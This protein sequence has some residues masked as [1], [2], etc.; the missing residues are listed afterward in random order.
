MRRRVLPRRRIIEVFQEF[1]NVI[2][3]VWVVP[4]GCTE[5]EIAMVAGGKDGGS[6]GLFKAGNGG[7]GGQV[8]YVS[9]M[10]VVPGERY[11]MIVGDK[12]Q[13]SQ[14][15]SYIALSGAGGKGGTNYQDDG[16]EP[17][18]GGDGRDGNYLFNGK[19]MD[20]YPSKYGAGGGAGAYIRGWDYG[21]ISGGNG[22][23][24][25]GGDGAGDYDNRGEVIDGKNGKSATF[26]GGG[27]GGASK[28][29]NDGAKPGYGGSGYRGI[30]I[31]HYFKY[32]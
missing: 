8:V 28:A 2:N 10:S 22:G 25:G 4:E 18:P 7:D 14:F 11:D 13:N 15:A 26:Y 19:Y 31:L 6:S 30:I 17:N 5:I 9:K 23:S 16:F 3:T 27:G 20:R 1:N 32:G 12:G 21:F 29:V 24:Y